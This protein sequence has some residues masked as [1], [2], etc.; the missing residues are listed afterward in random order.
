MASMGWSVVAVDLSSK[1]IDSVL[2]NARLNN[3]MLDAR[4][5]DMFSSIKENEKFPL[6][7]F[8]IPYFCCNSEQIQNMTEIERSWFWR[9]QDLI[10]FFTTAKNYLVPKGQIVLFTSSYADFHPKFLKYLASKVGLKLDKQVEL[11]NSWLLPA[12]QDWQE[13]IINEVL[14]ACFFIRV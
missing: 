13:M 11:P 5:S 12:I 1:A 8:N 9:E 2:H 4:L 14:T 3:I 7:T 6:I 10:N